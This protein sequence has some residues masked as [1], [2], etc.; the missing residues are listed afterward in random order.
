MKDANPVSTPLDSNISLESNKE[1]GEMNCSNAYASSVLRSGP[2]W[3]L[4]I[5]GKAETETSL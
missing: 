5:F 3:F 4:P 2:V 1:Q